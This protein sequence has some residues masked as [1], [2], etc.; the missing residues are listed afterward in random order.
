V[1]AL[2]IHILRAM[3][4]VPYAMKPNGGD[5]LR[6]ARLAKAVGV[7]PE[8]V[9]D[10]IARMEQSGVIAGYDV[11]PN[12]RHF[13]LEAEAFLLQ[14]P[15]ETRREDFRSKLG[16]VEGLLEVTFFLG[17]EACVD[18]AYRTRGEREHRLRALGELSGDHAPTPFFGWSM[19]PVKRSLTPLDWRILQA[20]RGRAKRS[21]V[22]VAQELGVG[23]R[24]VK[25]HYDRMAAE[26]SFFAKPILNPATDP[27]F[28]PL[29]LLFFLAPG[30]DGAATIAGILGAFD[31]HLVFGGRPVSERSGNFDVLLFVS[32]PREA[33]RLRQQGA[34]FPGVV[35]VRALVLAD[36]EPRTDWI[37]DLIASR[38]QA[39]APA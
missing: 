10:R 24:T 25:R 35:R 26:G 18:L 33:E 38:I 9:R 6:P 12:L 13:G 7:T 37:D 39:A 5:A 8:T 22:E 30:A 11:V 23:Y 19:P 15:D 29:G 31:D 27:G 32:S 34:A 21:L 28:L 16:L 1:D 20:L 3:G 36:V 4:P 14:S 17:A 2:D